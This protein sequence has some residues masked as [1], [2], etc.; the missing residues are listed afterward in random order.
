MDEFALVR[1]GNTDSLID[2]DL[3]GKTILNFK[4]L[5]TFNI[6]QFKEK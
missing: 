1:L 2:L 6:K 5:L 3:H 4:W